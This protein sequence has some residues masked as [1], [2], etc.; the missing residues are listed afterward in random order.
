VTRGVA[1]GGQGTPDGTVGAS[2][3]FH[4]AGLGIFALIT[5]FGLADSLFHDHWLHGLLILPLAVLLDGWFASYARDWFPRRG[6]LEGTVLEVRGAR[7]VRRCDLASAEVI[8]VHMASGV[9]N[10]LNSSW[11]LLARQERGGP[12]VRLMMRGPDFQ[13]FPAEHLRMLADAIGQ[14][15][16]PVNETITRAVRRLNALADE[17]VAR[18]ARLAA[19]GV[20]ENWPERR[21]PSPIIPDWSHR[22]GKPSPGQPSQPPQSAPPP[23]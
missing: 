4:A 19:L 21:E 16:G 13:L 14:R 6:S 18:Q 9:G 23:R 20:K 3:I 22:T 1:L 5:T 2:L 10:L 17:Q 7:G 15:P 11:I 8:R 12:A